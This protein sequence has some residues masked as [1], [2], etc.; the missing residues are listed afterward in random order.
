MTWPLPQ[1]YN[2]AIQ[3]PRSSF[4]DPELREGEAI[5]NALGLP[6]PRSGN[7]ADVYEVRC[8]AAQTR[9][10][11]KCFTRAV[12]G[13]RERYREISNYLAQVKLPFFVDFSYLEEG[14]RVRG[15]WYP[16]LKMQWVEGLLLNEF[17]GNAL[18]KP[19]T[20]EALAEVWVRMA[21]RLREAP[22]AHGDLQ[23]GN[24]MLVPGSKTASLAVKLVDYDG[25]FV[26]TLAQGK[27]GEVGHPCYQ[28]PQR[29]LK[30]TYN[31]E[32]DRFPLLVV[33][34]ALRGL[35]VRGR[36]LWQRFDNEDNLLFREADLRAPAESALI[37]ELWHL[38]DAETHALVGNLILASRR[39]L[40]RTPLLDELGRTL[41]AAEERQVADLL[42][43]RR[44][45]VALAASSVQ[46][47]HSPLA[48]QPAPAESYNP[49]AAL[50]RS[51]WRALAE[52]AEPPRQR[53][54]RLRGQHPL[55]RTLGVWALGAALVAVL[56][57]GLLVWATR[58]KPG[59]AEAKTALEQTPTESGLKKVVVPPVRSPEEM[60][61]KAER[62]P[63]PRRAV[64]SPKPRAKQSPLVQVGSQ[65]GSPFYD[66]AEPHLL[67]G[68]NITKVDFGQGFFIK[69]I[70]PI[71]LILKQKHQ[72]TVHGEPEGP[73][74]RVEAKDGYA[75]GGIVASQNPHDLKIIFM[76]IRGQSLDP[77]DS[78]ESPWLCGRGR[79]PTTLLGGDGKPIVG[80]HGKKGAN[81]NALGLLFLDD[82]QT[83]KI[84]AQPQRP[85]ANQEQADPKVG[86]VR[87]FAKHPS[88]VRRMAVSSDGRWLLTACWDN[89]IRLFEIASGRLVVEFEKQPNQVHAVAFSPDGRFVYSGGPDKLI[90]VWD[91]RSGKKLRSWAGHASDIYHLAVF[92]DGR[93]L[94]SAGREKKVL[95][96][97]T[98]TGSLAARWDAGAEVESVAVSADGNFL[99]SG[100]Q[101]G[102]LRLWNTRTGQAQPLSGHKTA[103]YFVA[104]SPDG[105]HA[106]S[107]G[108]DG[109]I[110]LWDL[111]RGE[112][113][114]VLGGHTRVVW[115]VA[116]S[117]DGRQLLSAGDDATV[118]LWDVE[119]GKELRRFDGHTQRV[120]QAVFTPDGH[121][122]I[123]GGDD[124]TVRLWRLP[125]A[126]Q[127]ADLTE[128]PGEAP[129]LAKHPNTVRRLAV[130]SDG[131]W[132]LTACWDG[133]LRHFDLASGRLLHNYRSNGK[134]PC[135]TCIFAPDGHTMFTG[136]GGRE[137]HGVIVHWDLTTGWVRR[138]FA[139]HDAPI[140][141]LAA[142]PDG[143]RLVSCGPKWAWVIWDVGS[144]RRI[145]SQK[146]AVPYNTVAVSRDGTYLAAGG[147]DGVL[148]LWEADSTRQVRR[149]QGHTG[150]VL[151][152][153]FSADG[154]SIM[155]SSS[156][157]TIRFWD[158][159][160]GRQTHSCSGH[161]NHVWSVA[162][163][164]DEKRVVSA[165]QDATVRLWDVASGQELHRFEG[166]VG[167]VFDAVFTTDGQ[168]VISAGEDKTVRV[169]RLPAELK[170]T[171][172]R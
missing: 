167:R 123:S 166:H 91:T 99:L 151:S 110:H 63:P 46:A 102:V 104:F 60:K 161:T 109:T 5:T 140:Y 42:G 6:M 76:R 35:Q 16:I 53:P 160:T 24:V 124:T 1:D 86:E 164:P 57:I 85:L 97:D 143:K 139:D 170:V 122:A 67:I 36:K 75:I 165:G 158:V 87:Q 116:F 156:D 117:P 40:E 172:R 147:D 17:V 26:P 18:D 54:R 146:S 80:I 14:I 33:A 69:S 96:W 59:P 48:A 98:Q 78:Y 19:A 131:R 135:E 112:Q 127:I 38:D 52:D 11:V 148:G 55:K 169:W 39:P 71:Y 159:A 84:R 72:S 150:S 145:S 92:P 47:E 115:S 45:A 51:D 114:R 29:V 88:T 22:L 93:R 43:I 10:A 138:R 171:G 50:A 9:W 28:H 64:S 27:S 81:V 3:N 121:Y 4:S 58:Q 74:T 61:V 21:R 120:R 118:R 94:V 137:N 129:Q 79:E 41:E 125:T 136:S 142:F 82:E 149:F 153:A 37:K 128:R 68:F 23:H 152:T 89:I 111:T 7:F 44:R 95:L 49:I 141:H 15:E 73:I 144:G 168:S 83:V 103:I 65:G 77:K 108:D 70:Q 132:L 62:P 34:A 32:V 100:G 113:Q 30:G 154:R 107:A 90:S 155:S 56:L 13:L 134:A 101:E 163:S 130:S 157:G 162:F 20:L 2:E 31:L 12:A 8:P 105:K 126:E 133:L 25:M 66:T 119:T 106:A